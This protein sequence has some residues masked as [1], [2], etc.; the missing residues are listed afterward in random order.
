MTAR[1]LNI[2]DLQQ[3]LDDLNRDAAE[4]WALIGGRLSRRFD[5]DDFV[6]AFGF[7]TRVAIVAEKMNH[8]PDWSNVYSTV[9]VHLVTHEAGG[10]T[11]LDFALAQQM[12]RLAGH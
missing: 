7:M 9:E 5:F 12:E 3:A 4:E 6:T 2:T 11:G 10:I 8:H 1:I